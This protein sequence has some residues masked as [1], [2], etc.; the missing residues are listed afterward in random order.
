MTDSAI[1]EL[2]VGAVTILGAGAGSFIA[3]KMGLNTLSIEMRQL[4]K[5][6]SDIAQGERRLDGEMQASIE[7]NTRR[8]DR[9]EEKT[10]SCPS[11]YAPQN[12][13]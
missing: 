9:L 6:V 12:R 13:K 2:V 3:V 11:C 7:E 4:S 1:V 8:L 5:W 10:T